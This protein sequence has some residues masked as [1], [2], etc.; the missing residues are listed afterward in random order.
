MR[1]TMIQSMVRAGKSKP[2]RRELD[3]CMGF[4][5]EMSNQFGRETKATRSE[6]RGRRELSG[7]QVGWSA[8]VKKTKRSRQ[9]CPISD[10]DL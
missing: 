1:R 3:N 9:S 2:V 8:G 10:K 6:D 7:W 4:T 5:R